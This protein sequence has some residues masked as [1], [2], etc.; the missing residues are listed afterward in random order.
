MARQILKLKK[1]NVFLRILIPILKAV[2][3]ILP[4]ILIGG[5]IRLFAEQ[6][7]N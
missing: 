4:L 5:G 3:F 2:L 7:I 1:K 6:I